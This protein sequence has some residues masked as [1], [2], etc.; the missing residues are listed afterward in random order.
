[1]RVEAA[2]SQAIVEFQFENTTK[3]APIVEFDDLVI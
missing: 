3:I 1:M 2:L